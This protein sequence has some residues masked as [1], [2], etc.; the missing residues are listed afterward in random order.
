MGAPNPHYGTGIFRRRL[1]WQAGAGEVR[2]A[3]EDSNHGF[4]LRLQHDGRCITAVS[5]EPLRH[6]FTTCP[7]A[8]ASLQRIVG[9]PLADVAAQREHLPQADNCTHLVDMA[10]LAAAHAAHAADIGQARSFDIAVADE[11]EGITQ[12]R[13][14][15][16]GQPVHDWA[17]RAHTLESPA[18]LAG[19]PVMRGFYAWATQVF[20]DMPLEAAQ[21]LQ[22][23]YFVAQSRRWNTQPIEAH[24]ASTDGIP[25]GACYS[26]NTGAVERAL[27]IQGSVRDYTQSSERLLQFTDA[28]NAAT[29]VQ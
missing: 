28:P 5:A 21:A 18:G 1:H 14:E 8:V 23:G 16:D 9:L 17:I 26:Y 19:R 15:C 25:V 3:L 12:A 20:T 24:P 27:R 11:H 10:L 6:P 7:E 4:R 22:R 29:E 13:I 2:V